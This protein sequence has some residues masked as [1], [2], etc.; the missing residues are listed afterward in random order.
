[1]QVLR[2]ADCPPTPWKNGGGITR[3]LLAV[4]AHAGIDDFLLRLSVAEVDSDGPFSRFDGIDR[5]L[6]IVAGAGLQLLDEHGGQV[7]N[8]DSEPL[9]FAGEQAISSRRLDGAVRDVNI[10]TRRSHCRHRA[11]QQLVHGTLALEHAHGLLLFVAAGDQLRIADGTTLGCHDALWQA[12]PGRLT[13]HAPQPCRLL[14]AEV[15]WT[16]ANTDAH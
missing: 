5:S 4:P 3:Q 16:G 15:E 10:M 6:A 13:L 7:L 14:L 2:F 1:M 11:W 8:R 12:T 9:A